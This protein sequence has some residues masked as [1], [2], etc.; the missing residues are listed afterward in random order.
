MSGSVRCPPC[1]PGPVHSDNRGVHRGNVAFGVLLGLPAMVLVPWVYLERDGS[2]A[3][4]SLVGAVVVAALL[5]WRRPATG[6]GMTVTPCSSLS[7]SLSDS[8]R[9]V[10]PRALRS[11]HPS[12]HAALSASVGQ[13]S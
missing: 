1:D 13:S 4:L 2:L 10:S 9:S 5:V 12:C 7:L 11:A 8:S 3:A 6:L